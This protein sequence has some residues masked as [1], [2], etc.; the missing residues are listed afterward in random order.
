MVVIDY[1]VLILEQV[2]DKADKYPKEGNSMH[3]SPQFFRTT[4]ELNRM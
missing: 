1:V 2:T 3:I 4:V